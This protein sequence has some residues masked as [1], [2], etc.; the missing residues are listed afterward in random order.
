MEQEP[1]TPLKKR[2][3]ELSNELQTGL[4][5][6]LARGVFEYLENHNDEVIN[7]R[8]V[9]VYTDDP[10]VQGLGA[11]EVGVTLSALSGLGFLEETG[12]GS[13]YGGCTSYR[14]T[15]PGETAYPER[16]QDENGESLN[17]DVI[18]NEILEIVED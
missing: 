2:Y 7:S 12:T 3:S 1:G 16:S 13:S 4:T 5:G 10:L 18:Q 9:V 17:W 8:N 6:R 15:D 11:S 14:E